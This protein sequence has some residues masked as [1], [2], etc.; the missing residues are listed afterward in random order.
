MTRKKINPKKLIIQTLEETKLLVA[1][2]WTDIVF[3]TIETGLNS[4]RIVI[5]LKQKEL[6]ND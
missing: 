4:T 6:N 3:Y 2:P 5:E 1:S